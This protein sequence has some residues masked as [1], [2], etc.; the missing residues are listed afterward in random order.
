MHADAPAGR[1][2]NLLVVEGVGQLRQAAIGPRSRGVELPGALHIEGLVGPFA[3]EF[4]DECVEASLLLQDVA[5]CWAGGL[6][7]EGQVHALVAPVLLGAARL[8]ALDGDAQPEPPHG[9]LGEVVEAV[10][11][12]EG[13]A[14][15]GAD[16]RGQAALAEELPAGLEG[17]LFLGG[18]K[19]FA[20]QQE[21]RG[22]VGDGQ[23]VTV[24]A[25]A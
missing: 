2:E 15:V 16:G 7:L 23:G 25:V 12:G 4:M 3:V 18:F 14:V 22:L 20:Q 24:L 21:A 19:G 1:H 5:T 9:E 13:Q 10:G 11:A 17:A 8:D 6:L